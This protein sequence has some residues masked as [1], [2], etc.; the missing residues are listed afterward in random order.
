MNRWAVSWRG[1]LSAVVVPLL[2]AVIFWG[3]VAAQAYGADPDRK[4][5]ASPLGAVASL[6]EFRLHPDFRIE[7]AAA[8]PQVI[9]PVALRFDENGRM[10]VVEMGDYPNGPA[11]GGRPLSR[12]RWL[13]DTDGD[14]RYETSRVFADGLLFATGVQP[15]ADGI[16]VTVAGELLYLADTDGDGVADDSDLCPDQPEDREADDRF[17]AAAVDH[18]TRRV[19][20]WYCFHRARPAIVHRRSADSLKP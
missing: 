3:A 13:E 16:L 9:D 18:L 7:L 11:A 10:W 2:S 20:R 15:W 12:V 1:G 8:E 17:A 4:S 5:P 14:G 19:R 6:S